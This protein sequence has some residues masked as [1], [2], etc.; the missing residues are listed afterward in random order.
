MWIA[1]SVRAHCARSERS[2]QPTGKRIGR[3]YCT[4]E[5]RYR[6]RSRLH[7][8]RRLHAGCRATLGQCSS[9]TRRQDCLRRQ[10]CGRAAFHRP[11]DP[12]VALAR[13]NAAAVVSGFARACLAC[14]EPGNPSRPGRPARS[15]SAVRSHPRLRCRPP[16]YGLDTRRR[17]GR[18][19]LPAQRPPHAADVGCPGAGPAGVSHQQFTASGLGELRGAGGGG[20]NARHAQPAER[21]SGPR[22]RRQPQRQPPR[23]RHASGAQ[24]SAARH[25]SGTCSGRRCRPEANERRGHYRDGGGSRGPC[26]RGGVRRVAAHRPAHHARAPLP[27]LRPERPERCRTVAALLGDTRARVERHTRC[28]LREGH[29]RRRLRFEIRGAAE[30]LQPSGARLRQAVRGTSPAER[31]S[32][33]TGRTRLSGTRPCHWRQDGTHGAGCPGSCCSVPRRSRSMGSHIRWRT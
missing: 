12:R 7:P 21:R 33:K 17:L 3:S 14:A 22:C 31:T 16:T 10:R 1:G 25:A 15:R 18:S 27:A 24:C 8:R 5:C 13:A 26:H 23:N 9:G 2:S 4:S 6:S 19:G 28:Q 29:S 20:H 11:A 32:N 30:A